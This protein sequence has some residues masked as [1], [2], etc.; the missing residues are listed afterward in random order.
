MFCIDG[1]RTTGVAAGAVTLKGST[2]EIFDRD[3]LAVWQID[4]NNQRVHPTRAEVEGCQEIAEEWLEWSAEWLLAGIPPTRQFFIYEDFVLNRTPQSWDREGISP[5]RVNALVMGMLVK[6]PVVWVPQTASMAKQRWNDDRLKRA[7]LWTPG[8]P[9]G[10]DATRHA[11][12]WI[13][14]QF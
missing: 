11:A 8:L 1:G 7:N 3:P 6:D 10:R 9:H 4:C 2:A 5:A 13:V 12:L 14:S